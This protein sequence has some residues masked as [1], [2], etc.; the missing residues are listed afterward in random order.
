MK[1][2]CT[3]AEVKGLPSC[4]FTPGRS[5][6]AMVS[7]SGETVHDVASCGSSLNCG[8][9]VTSPSNILGEMV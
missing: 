5:L 6:K 4:H 1:V 7:P 2:N 3:S 8:S 9:Y